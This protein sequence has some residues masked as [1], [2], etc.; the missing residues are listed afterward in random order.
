MVYGIPYFYSGKEGKIRMQAIAADVFL[1]HDG[2]NTV[3]FQ[4]KVG[5]YLTTYRISTVVFTYL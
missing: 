1:A 5:K 2:V 3:V 4:G